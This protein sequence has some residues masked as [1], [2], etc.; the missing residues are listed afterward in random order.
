MAG[1]PVDGGMTAKDKSKIGN[2]LTEI[3]ELVTDILTGVDADQISPSNKEKNILELKRIIP[4]ELSK[5][6][7]K[8]ISLEKE[9]EQLEQCKKDISENLF[10]GLNDDV[11]VSYGTS[12]K[13]DGTQKGAELPQVDLKSLSAW[14]RMNEMKTDLD[15]QTRV[16]EV[17]IIRMQAQI[18][19]L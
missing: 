6:T 7:H 15:S 9:V 10:E 1:E 8:I 19:Q 17:E 2:G 16:I 18:G 13:A 14:R 5:V 12:G 3:K 4:V 11:S